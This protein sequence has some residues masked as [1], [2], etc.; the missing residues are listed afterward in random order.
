[1]KPV[2]NKQAHFDYEI[3]EKFEAGLKLTGAEVKAVKAGG[4]NLK[5][6]YVTLKQQP[7]TEVFLINAHI[8]KYKPAGEQP[9][10]DPTGSRKLLLR[11][12]EINKLTG[13]LRQK[14]LTFVPLR[15]YTKHNLVKLE[16]GVGRGKKRFEK[17]DSIKKRENDRKIERAMK[18]Y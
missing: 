14:G 11:K 10:Y 2:Y 3:L 6:S 9:E 16:F 4:I 13:I 18:Q 15:V 7:K 1:M 8:S 12:E 5:G 17:K